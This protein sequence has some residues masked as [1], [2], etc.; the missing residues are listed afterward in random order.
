MRVLVKIPFQYISV[1]RAKGKPEERKV[2]LTL[3]SDWNLRW[4]EKRNVEYN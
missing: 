3:D 1:Q 2:N 4:E